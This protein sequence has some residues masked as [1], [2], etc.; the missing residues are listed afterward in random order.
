MYKATII[1]PTKNEE[2]TIGK[3]I[4]DIKKLGK[5][6]E[7][8]VVDKS[9][10]STPIICK[11]LGVRVIKQKNTGKGNAM[12]IGVEK[13]SSDV[14]VFIDGDDTYPTDVIPKMVKIVREK[15]CVVNASRTKK[16]ESKF[17]HM[18][19]NRIISIFASILYSKTSDLLTGLRAMKKEDFERLNLKSIGFEIETEMHIKISKLKMKIVEIP[20]IYKKRFGEKK[21]SVI[22]D[23]IKIIKLLILSNFGLI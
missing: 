13:A 17:S 21:F 15:D 5:D 22:K 14:V 7:I 20:I 2:R 8:I 23:T 19:V 18:L 10:D 9:T 3:V 16:W 4:S 11:K 12:K 6:Y 1:I